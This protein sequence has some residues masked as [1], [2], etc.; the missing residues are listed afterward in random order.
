M[1]WR[2]I[3]LVD[4][5]LSKCAAEPGAALGERRLI[6][7]SLAPQDPVARGPLVP[8]PINLCSN[9]T[10]ANEKPA[11]PEP[12]TPKQQQVWNGVAWVTVPLAPMPRPPARWSINPILGKPT[13]VIRQGPLPQEFVL[14]MEGDQLLVNVEG[15]GGAQIV[16]RHGVAAVLDDDSLAR[17]PADVRKGFNEY[18]SSALC[19]LYNVRFC[20][21]LIVICY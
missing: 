7:K 5:A 6:G 12:A 14:E 1:T 3:A 11:K 8:K 21:W 20:Y 18:V 2:A 4:P 13:L 19:H 17:K 10:V 9:G 15:E 16:V